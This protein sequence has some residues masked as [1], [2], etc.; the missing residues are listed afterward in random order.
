MIQHISQEISQENSTKKK[1]RTKIPQFFTFKHSPSELNTQKTE[2]E[3]SQIV[4][5]EEVPTSEEGSAKI[6]DIFIPEHELLIDDFIVIGIDRA[7]LVK[8][9]IKYDELLNLKIPLKSQILWTKNFFSGDNDTA[10]YN[11]LKEFIFPFGYRGE[12]L[13][14][15][16]VD[17]FLL[18]DKL[19]KNIN[20]I[21]FFCLN[22]EETV[23]ENKEVKS[24]IL[25]E[26]NPCLFYY[27]FCVTIDVF[28]CIVRIKI[29][30]GK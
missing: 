7:T 6:E 20:N 1:N 30:K 16:D 10:K 13:D 29:Y 21:H 12:V 15:F 28:Y 18:E 8:E 2:T 22:S 23:K 5:T 17:D 24:K 14:S 3:D 27:Y 25:K 9:D 26:A 11:C 4:L 19:A